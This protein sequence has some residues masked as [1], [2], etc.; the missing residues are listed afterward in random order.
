MGALGDRGA[1]G[2]PV[3]TKCALPSPGGC[4]EQT[5]VVMELPYWGFYSFVE[6]V[7]ASKV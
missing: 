4:S 5:R 2:L 6:I 1:G 3:L 7:Q